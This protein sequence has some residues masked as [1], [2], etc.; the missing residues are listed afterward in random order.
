MTTVATVASGLSKRYSRRQPWVLD[1]LDLRFEPGTLTVV[2]GANGCGKS[3]L[4]RV[5]AGVSRPTAG[6]ITQRP[7]QVGY[8]PERL[9]ARLQMTGR[10]YLAHMG[11]LRRLDSS[12]AGARGEDLAARLSLNPGLDVPVRSLSKGNSQKVAL[13]QAFLAPVGLLLLDEPWSG[14]DPSASEGLREEMSSPRNEGTAVVAT[15]HRADAIP[16][17]DRCLLLSGGHLSEIVPPDVPG[18]RA[19]VVVELVAPHHLARGD[20]PPSWV[21]H[22]EAVPAEGVWRVSVPAGPTVDQLLAHA[23]SA[24]WSVHRVDPGTPG[25]AFA[26]RKKVSPPSGT[27]GPLPADQPPEGPWASS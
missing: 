22:A 25:G 27:P 17:P 15:A 20:G 19:Q 2:V 13:A 24:G 7:R 18:T 11:R 12:Y 5:L 14:L 4:L 1:H 21:P 9:P 3:T 8:V 23:L 10:E 16:G 6:L 26:T